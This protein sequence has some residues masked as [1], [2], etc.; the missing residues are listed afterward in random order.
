MLAAVGGASLVGY[1]VSVQ[2]DADTTPQVKSAADNSGTTTQTAR[3][4][5][6]QRTTAGYDQNRVRE[7]FYKR[8]NEF[9][10]ERG[11]AALLPS[12]AVAKVADAHSENMAANDFFSHQDSSGQ[13]PEARLREGGVSCTT[14]GENIARTWWREQLT[15]GPGPSYIDSNR[16]LARALFAQW[17]TSDGHRK[18]ML[19]R[20]V[21]DVGLGLAQTPA[22]EIYATLNVC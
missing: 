22:G 8:F 6:E 14:S 2:P 11:R 10:S 9:R 15:E 17:R 12:S 20:G 5:T 4:T 7:L 18:I 21:N 13:G 3:R 16:D 1:D 19:L